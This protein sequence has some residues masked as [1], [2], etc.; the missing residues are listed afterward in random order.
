MTYINKIVFS[1]ESKLELWNVMTEKRIFEF[2]FVEEGENITCI[3]QS[4]VVDVIAIG[5]ESGKIK[6]INLLYN[7]ELLCFDQA[8]DGGSIKALSFSSDV[9]LGVSLLASVTRSSNGGRNIVFWDL[10]QKKIHS[11]LKDAHS[12]KQVSD[13]KF[14]ANEPV[15]ISS[16]DE[17]NSIKMWLFEQGLSVPRLLRQR[18]GHADQ[19]YKIRFYGGQDDPVMQGARNIISCSADGQLRD[20]SLLNEFQ[21]MNFSQ[22]NLKKGLVRNEEGNM[23]LGKI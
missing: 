4:P 2:S 6:L 17:G 20:I 7:Q 9:A 5:L 16:S 8:Q 12:G 1:C 15:L 11:I 19:P 13:I 22:K 23:Q 14:M 10:N 3:E 18:T 21:S